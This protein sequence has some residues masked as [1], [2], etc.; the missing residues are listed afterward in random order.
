MDKK[1]L[2]VDNTPDGVAFLRDIVTPSHFTM[3]EALSGPQAIEVHRWKR[4]DLIIMDLQMPGMDGE[5]VTRAIRADRLL[6]DVSILIISDTGRPGIRERCLAFGANDFLA[7]PF[8]GTEL[9]RRV[10]QLFNIAMRKHTALLA[11]VEVTD[12]GPV[13]EPFVARIVNLSMSGLLLEA[14]VP[15]EGRV[16]GVKFV[17]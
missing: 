6:R 15:L 9:M 3:F 17:V 14:D 4:V 10:S 8:K 2:L 12:N 7:K 11:Q 13:I 1:V 16:V 5:Q